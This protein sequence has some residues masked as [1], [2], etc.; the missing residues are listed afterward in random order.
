LSPLCLQCVDIMPFSGADEG[1]SRRLTDGL[2]VQVL[3]EEPERKTPR[4]SGVFLCF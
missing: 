1:D 3:P 2:Q 4:L